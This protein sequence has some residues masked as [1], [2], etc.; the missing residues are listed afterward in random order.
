MIQKNIITLL[1]L[2]SL[3]LVACSTT[4]LQLKGKDSSPT[5]E[6]TVAEKNTLKIWWDKGYYPEE[7]AALKNFLNDWEKKS[8]IKVKL[9]LYNQDELIKITE[10]SLNTGNL[11]DVLFGYSTD[12]AVSPT[13]AWQGKLADVSE[14]IEPVKNLYIPSALAAVNLYNNVEKKRSFYAVPIKQNSIHIFYRRDLLEAAGLSDK[15]IPNDWE[16]FWDFWKQ[17]QD[18]LRQQG[19]QNIYGI[20]LPLSSSASD[21]Y[22]IFEQILE[23][24]NIKIVDEK[25]E[26]L[27]DKPQVRE[28]II[29]ALTWYADF[30]KQG[31]VPPS[32]L[33]WQDPDNNI[34]L[35]NR[36][37]LMTPNP[38]LSIP[39]SQKQDKEVYYNQIVTREF[40]LTPDGKQLRYLVSIKQAIVPASSKNQQIAQDFLSYLIQ[41]HNLGKYVQGSAGRWFPVMEPLLQ[42][43]FWQDKKDPHLSIASQQFTQR[44]TRPLYSVINPAYTKVQQ[45]N[46]WGKALKSIAGENVSPEAAAD[47]AI[48]EIKQI[49]AEWK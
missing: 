48:K 3:G 25:G 5:T 20:G 18:K 1:L 49:F 42:E 2:V 6:N 44:E 43:S 35:L 24:Y 15:D 36:V 7:D 10:I 45:R 27:L 32:A 33:N 11:P 47:E 38:S 39:A 46:V 29:K 4:V 16:G 37:V 28:G 34:N 31:Y 40:P 14:T 22:F 41:P 19:N 17:A 26:L 12:L 30:Y 21:T 9:N 8:G 23:A 13:L